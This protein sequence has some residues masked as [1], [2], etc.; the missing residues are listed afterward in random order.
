MINT[1]EQSCCWG[2]RQTLLLTYQQTPIASSGGSQGT[3]LNCEHWAL[4]LASVSPHGKQGRSNLPKKTSYGNGTGVRQ[5]SSTAWKGDCRHWCGGAGRQAVGR[6][7]ALSGLATVPTPAPPQCQEQQLHGYAV[8]K[9]L[10]FPWREASALDEPSEHPAAAKTTAP[11]LVRGM[12]LVV[13]LAGDIVGPCS[14]VPQPPNPQGGTAG[15]PQDPTRRPPAPAWLSLEE[16][17]DAPE[18]ARNAALGRFGIILSLPPLFSHK[19]LHLIPESCSEALHSPFQHIAGDGESTGNP[20]IT[21]WPHVTQRSLGLREPPA[22]RQ[23]WSSGAGWGQSWGAEECG[24][25]VTT[26]TGTSVLP[27]G[28]TRHLLQLRSAPNSS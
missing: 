21:S 7:C 27:W 25:T 22:P 18:Y 19:G 1:G 6:G 12:E 23:G 10:P 5:G 14:I 8:S 17:P 15:G 11:G 13:L 28:C 9:L 26:G 2:L 24:V 20:S 16:P 3:L 4:P